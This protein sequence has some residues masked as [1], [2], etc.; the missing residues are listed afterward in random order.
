MTEPWPWGRDGLDEAELVEI[1]ATLGSTIADSAKR[2]AV[3]ALTR[4]GS[5]RM[6]A[7]R[8][9][10]GVLDLR[11]LASGNRA[12]AFLVIAQLAALEGFHLDLTPEAFQQHADAIESGRA[13]LVDTI[14]MFDRA[15]H[16]VDSHGRASDT[17]LL[18]QH[19]ELVPSIVSAYEGLGI[20]RQDLIAAG[21]AGLAE[22]LIHFCGEDERD[23]AEFAGPIIDAAIRT[24][25]A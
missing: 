9:M 24:F 7:A 22:A 8:V 25:L 16:A 19:M 18:S 12:F 14:G 1:A 5:L 17:E 4:G 20:S 10:R 2:G 11:P 13:G 21:N 3:A 15:L 6:A 23:F